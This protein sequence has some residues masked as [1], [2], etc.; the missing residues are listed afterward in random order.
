MAGTLLT[1]ELME[2]PSEGKDKHQ[3][4][5]HPNTQG[6]H[7]AAV[8]YSDVPATPAPALVPVTPPAA[9]AP[10]PTTPDQLHTTHD[11]SHI[12]QWLTFMFWGLTVLAL[13]F[14]TSSVL[15]RLIAG[16]DSSTFNY[17][18]IASLIILL[19]LAFVCDVIYA[20]Q[21]PEKK[22]GASSRIMAA[23]AIIF[24]LFAILSL[25]GIAWNIVAWATGQGLDHSSSQAGIVSGLFILMYYLATFMRTLN[26][27]HIRWIPKVYRFAILGVIIV[28]VI[29]GFTKPTF[30]NNKSNT[31]TGRASSPSYGFNDNS[32]SS[33]S[34]P[35]NNFGSN[36]KLEPSVVGGTQ[37]DIPTLSD[38]ST[39]GQAALT[40]GA[41]CD[42]S[43]ANIQ[44]ATGKAGGNYTANGFTCTSTK[45]GSNTQWSSYWD[46]NFYSYNC[47]SGSKQTAFNL[48]TEAQSRSSSATSNY[49]Y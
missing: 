29:L 41:T 5:D 17:Y 40:G 6:H 25:L 9:A 7:H 2:D 16:T 36:G 22:I 32:S 18:V 44:G 43:D 8:T 37:C 27:T 47:T 20:K 28:F 35:S 19:P 11:G 30:S 45:Q 39:T 42:D 13:A 34:T 3:P 49:N 48:Q 46:D 24:A 1:I 14:L 4:H 21:E 38:G 10:L 33:S 15:E 23:Y 12:L 26:P 31:T